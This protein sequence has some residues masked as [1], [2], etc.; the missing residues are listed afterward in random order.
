MQEEVDHEDDDSFVLI[1]KAKEHQEYGESIALSD[2]SDPRKCKPFLDS[3]IL[4]LVKRESALGRYT[5]ETAQT[6]ASMGKLYFHM[7]HPRAAVMLRASFRIEYFL[8][9]KCSGR[10]AGDFKGFLL[11]RGLS[12][13]D[14]EEI[15]KDILFSAKYELEG[16]IL[17]RFGD[18]RAAAMEYQKAARLEE[19][20]FGKDNPDLAFLW[21]KM[22]CLASIKKANM[23]TIDFDESDRLGSKWMNEVQ[24][25]ISSTVSAGIIKGDKYYQ[26]LLYGKAIREY[27]KATL[28]D[29]PRPIPKPKPRRNN[30]R[31]STA[32]MEQELQSMIAS[33]TSSVQSRPPRRSQS[34]NLPANARPQN[35]SR[36]VGNENATAIQVSAEAV[37]FSSS[38]TQSLVASH[39]SSRRSRSSV[40]QMSISS[41]DLSEFEEEE[42]ALKDHDDKSEDFSVAIASSEATSDD[43]SWYSEDPAKNKPSSQKQRPFLA[44]SLYEM[45]SKN[46]SRALGG[47]TAESSSST[48]KPKSESALRY[49]AIKPATKFANRAMKKLRKKT[50]AS[51]KPESDV[52]ESSFTPWSSPPPTLT[53]AAVD[54]ATI[55]PESMRDNRSADSDSN[56]H[57]SPKQALHHQKGMPVIKEVSSPES[58]A[59]PLT[60]NNSNEILSSSMRSVSERRSARSRRTAPIRRLSSDSFSDDMLIEQPKSLRRQALD[61]AKAKR[62]NN[63]KQPRQRAFKKVIPTN[64]N[65]KPISNDYPRRGDAD[66]LAKVGGSDN[67]FLVFEDPSNS[68][69]SPSPPSGLSKPSWI[70]H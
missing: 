10:I 59:S 16:D 23:H 29:R 26:S 46:S 34:S 47:E 19:L 20:A 54:Q 11:E 25:H 58:S 68:S 41:K 56:L 3:L 2:A 5:Y 40:K 28:G 39:D 9:G 18:R 8:Y 38:A 31:T 63:K 14:T 57:S 32:S 43:G 4:A 52:Q 15:R 50:K 7:H 53:V 49:M 69:S 60:D 22:A 6:Y 42:L 36:A 67:P 62:Q 1:E 55:Y 21:R 17:R 35:H 13:N 61:R 30:R 24:D 12:D 45:V 66:A 48:K 27:V 51:A 44:T 33:S 37:P 65:D 64:I 70:A